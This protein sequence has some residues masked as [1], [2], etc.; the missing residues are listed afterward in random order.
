[1]NRIDHELLTKCIPLP[2][3]FPVGAIEAL[4]VGDKG[5]M[6]LCCFTYELTQYKKG[7]GDTEGAYKDTPVVV[8]SGGD[9][10]DRY[11]L[12]ATSVRLKELEYA[13]EQRELSLKLK[14]VLQEK[15]GIES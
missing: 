8:Y 3:G 13:A 5:V 9:A 12:Y 15:L 7:I 11:S 6:A 14:E 1:M 4:Y 2:E 10:Q